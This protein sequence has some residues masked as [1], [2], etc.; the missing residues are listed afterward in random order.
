MKNKNKCANIS[1]MNNSKTH[2]VQLDYKDEPDISENNIL[3]ADEALL[4][5]LLKDQTTK[6][7][8]LW[9]TDNYDKYGFG[10]KETREITIPLITGKNAKIIRP[11]INKTKKEQLYR[12]RD[13]AEVFTPSWICNSQNNLIDIA[14]FGQEGMFNIES[15]KSWITNKR[16]ISFPAGKTWQDYVLARRMEVSCG[17]APYLVSRYD[18][19]IGQMLSVED[20][21]GILD[22]KLRIINEN[23]TTEEEWILWS[24]KAVQS[25][26]GFE[27]QGDSLLL[28]RENIVLSYIDYF[29]A[30]FGKLPTVEL[31]RKIA[32]IVSWN[33]WQMDGLKFVVPLSCH[34][35]VH[36]EQDLFE[37][38]TETKIIC[39]G[40]SKNKI[41][42][43]NGVYC[44][45][46]DWQ[47]DKVTK[48]VSLLKGDRR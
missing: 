36:V 8:I 22:R 12:I 48:A 47:E 44:K 35:E 26:Y 16:N 11:R 20:R 40:C 29:K 45:I 5:I 10:Y 34:E 30:R 24:V 23:S 19:T 9:M 6:K 25:T 7:N 41:K 32:E 3:N 31:I 37:G 2:E 14:W 15:E 17:E 38:T 1:D 27:W 42:K 43:H 33:I 28:A 39:E 46:K 18:T 21:I 13:K 4:S